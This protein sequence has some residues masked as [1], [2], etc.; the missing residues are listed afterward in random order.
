MAYAFKVTRE[1]NHMTASWSGLANGT[2][3]DKLQVGAGYKLKS[4]TIAST[5]GAITIN[6][7]NDE[8]AA[9]FVQMKDRTGTAI[10]CASGASAFFGT[11]DGAL[12]IQPVAGTGVTAGTVDA[13]FERP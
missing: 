7:A 13:R 3:I 11:P 8:A 6:A 4:I 9:N 5:G 2:T 10:S 1:M 12:F